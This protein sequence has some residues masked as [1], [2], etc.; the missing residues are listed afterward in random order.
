MIHLSTHSSQTYISIFKSSIWTQTVRNKDVAVQ[1]MI[2]DYTYMPTLSTFLYG[3][4]GIP[5]LPEPHVINLT[6]PVE[7][8]PFNAY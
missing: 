8:L 4:R 5:M 3:I 2:D 1:T 7:E 6:R